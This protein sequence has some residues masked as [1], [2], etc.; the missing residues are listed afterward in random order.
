MQIL[1]NPYSN[2]HISFVLQNAPYDACTGNVLISAVVYVYTCIYVTPLVTFDTSDISDQNT[3]RLVTDFIV[4]L[5]I[6]FPG[7][8]V[9]SLPFKFVLWFIVFTFTL[10]LHAR[11]RFIHKIQAQLVLAVFTQQ[12]PENN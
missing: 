11:W 6:T 8:I 10:L 5:A 2:A 3:K 4:T 9:L 7:S 12:C 1:S